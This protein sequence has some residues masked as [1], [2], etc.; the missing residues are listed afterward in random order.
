MK[1]ETERLTLR[2]WRDDDLGA[3]EMP[4]RRL[5]GMAAVWSGVTIDCVDPVR[6]ARFWAELLGR[7]AGPSRDGWVY[8]GERGDPQPRPARRTSVRSPRAWAA[9][10]PGAARS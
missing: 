9:W 2:R 8:L 1:L 4:D 3:L 5:T 6:V 10:W 7:E